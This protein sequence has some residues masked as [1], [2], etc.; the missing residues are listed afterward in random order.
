MYLNKEL[1]LKI[2]LSYILCYD[3]SPTQKHMV[4]P[5]EEIFYVSR[6][7]PEWGPNTIDDKKFRFD[8]FVLSIEN[9]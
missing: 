6:I 4:I 9:G 5:P 8:A 7:G 3:F 1:Y 2:L